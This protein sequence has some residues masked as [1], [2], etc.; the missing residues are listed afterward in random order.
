M[1]RTYQMR[2]EFRMGARAIDF[3][4]AVFTETCNNGTSGNPV[5]LET[6][7]GVERLSSD[8]I[9][10][11]ERVKLQVNHLDGQRLELKCRELQ[12]LLIEEE[13]V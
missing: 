1:I 10:V 9:A 6:S 13:E 8:M 5:I 2:R 12:W 11:W 4:R 7:C 3:T